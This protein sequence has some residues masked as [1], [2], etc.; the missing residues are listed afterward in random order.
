MRKRNYV[1]RGAVSHNPNE[2]RAT[3]TK[4]NL[5]LLILLSIL[6]YVGCKLKN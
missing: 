4:P 2:G 6:K 1:L 3:E 5:L